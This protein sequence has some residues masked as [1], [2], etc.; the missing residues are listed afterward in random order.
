MSSGGAA[1]WSNPQLSKNRPSFHVCFGEI[2]LIRLIEM[3]R[4]DLTVCKNLPGSVDAADSEQKIVDV[5]VWLLTDQSRSDAGDNE[6]LTASVDHL[7]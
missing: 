3:M 4:H 6:K 1:L 5:F 2:V 7:P